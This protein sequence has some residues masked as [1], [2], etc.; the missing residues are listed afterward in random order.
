MIGWVGG[1]M[2]G[3]IDTAELNKQNHSTKNFIFSLIIYIFLD[4][5]FFRKLPQR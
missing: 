5:K 2:D 4:K 3:W 1:W